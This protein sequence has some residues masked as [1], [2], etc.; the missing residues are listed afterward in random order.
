M[1]VYVLLLSLMFAP[2][3]LPTVFEAR[4]FLQPAY[5][6]HS[7][8]EAGNSCIYLECVAGNKNS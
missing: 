1:L 3:P 7:D 4:V 2:P 6:V 5:M 8:S